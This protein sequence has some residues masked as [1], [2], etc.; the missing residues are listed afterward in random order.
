MN[1]C[2]RFITQFVAKV[3]CTL[4]HTHTVTEQVERIYFFS[5]PFMK[6]R[7]QWKLARG[8]WTPGG[9][10]LS[11]WLMFCGWRRTN[12]FSIFV[13]DH[14]A[15]AAQRIWAV[16]IEE[17]NSVL[18]ERLFV[19]LTFYF[20][21]YFPLLYLLLNRWAAS[22]ELLTPWTFFCREKVSFTGIV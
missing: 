6:S 21:I 5:T 10:G 2:F 17:K 14:K 12:E 20:I 7:P 15:A 22:N 4:S 8:W 9:L 3:K 16:R 1:F 18:T 11:V 13:A 19:S